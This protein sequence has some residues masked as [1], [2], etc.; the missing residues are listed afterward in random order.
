MS[1]ECCLPLDAIQDRDVDAAGPK[2]VAL[3][4]MRRAGLPVPDGFL[5][6][7]AA[8]RDHRLLRRG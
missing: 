7:A 2:A 4:R 6:P 1:T 3:A 8:Y 5:V